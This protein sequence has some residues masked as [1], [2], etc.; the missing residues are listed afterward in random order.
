MLGLTQKVLQSTCTH[1]SITTAT[2]IIILMY[3]L[4][5]IDLPARQERAINICTVGAASDS[6]TIVGTVV[7]CF[8]CAVHAI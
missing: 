1:T 5:N 4:W 2:L 6:K 7:S 3:I 8:A